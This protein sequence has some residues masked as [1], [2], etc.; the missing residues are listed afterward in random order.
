MHFPPQVAG[1]SHRI[2]LLALRSPRLHLEFSESPC[3]QSN[4]GRRFLERVAYRSR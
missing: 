2:G 4:Q 1:V 3:T